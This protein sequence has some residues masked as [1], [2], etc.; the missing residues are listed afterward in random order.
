MAEAPLGPGET[1]RE[2]GEHANHGG[3]HPLPKRDRRI[4]IVEAGLLAVVALLAAWSGYAA[5]KHSTESRLTVA[6]AQTTRNLANT[7]HLEGLDVRLGDALIF[8][9]WLAAHAIGNPEAEAIAERRFR[10]GLR[11]AF[12]AWRATDPDTNPDAPPGPQSMP[13]YVQP[14]VEKARR[15]TEEGEELFAEGAEQGE[16]ADDY[17]RTTVYL[18]SVLFLVGISTQFPV[19]AARYGL[20]AI[21]A[22]ILVY[23]VVELIR[24][25]KP[26]L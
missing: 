23:S 4:S 9:S 24:L 25:P 19:R 2:I 18:A 14:D 12:D 16:T 22:V 21:A 13:E 20:I 10:P 11:A 1:A 15:L 8:N 6:S 26:V 3:D 7:A 17:V 5:A